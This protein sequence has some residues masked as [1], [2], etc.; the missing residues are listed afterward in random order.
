MDLREIGTLLK[1]ERLRQGLELSTAAKVTRVS[2][3]ALGAIE[4]GDESPLPNPVYI[5]GFIRNYARFLKLEPEVIDNALGELRF[6]SGNAMWSPSQRLPVTSRSTSGLKIPVIA[7]IL[8]LLTGGGAALF[9]LRSDNETSRVSESPPIPLESIS[10]QR[11]EEAVPQPN[12]TPPT[13]QPRQ[14]HAEGMVVPHDDQPGVP[15]FLVDPP[16]QAATHEPDL[17]PEEQPTVR[18]D[19]SLQMVEIDNMRLI[20][21]PGSLRADFEIRNL[22]NNLI[23]GQIA[24]SFISKSDDTFPALRHEEIPRFSIRNY[25]PVT[26]PLNF[27]PGLNLEDLTRIQFVVTAPDGTYL[28]VRTYPIEQNWS[29]P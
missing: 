9:H 10:F 15:A 12:W 24:I 19:I 4:E 13:L 2:V 28:L 27:P 26:T 25:R 16:E 18:P 3:S 8:I 7:L 23:S 17:T 20:R 11:S 21:G 5:K 14:E 1:E 6:A 22:T 29:R